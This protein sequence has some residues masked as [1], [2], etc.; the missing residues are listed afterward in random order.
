MTEQAPTILDTR[1]AERLKTVR[2]AQAMS[3]SGLAA[4]VGMDSWQIRDIEDGH[5][6][7]PS[8]L[9]KQRRVSIGE[10]VALC[11]ALD[12][13]LAIMLRSEPIDLA[14]LADLAARRAS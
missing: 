8:S 1:F 4:R 7:R 6:R 3:R 13:P 2:T 12:V 14:T 11:G 10:A 9:H 5:N